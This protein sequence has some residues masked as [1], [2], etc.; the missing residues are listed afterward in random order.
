MNRTKLLI[1]PFNGN[2]LE[3]L[4]C[5]NDEE[6]EF[7]GFIDDDPEKTSEHYK[8]FQ[9]GILHQYPEFKLLAVPGGPES[10]QKRK[11]IIST[12]NKDEDRFIS[13]IHHTASIGRNVKIGSNCLIMA[14]VVLTSNAIIGNHVCILPNSVVHHDS[15]IGDYT[16]IGSKVV[17]AGSTSVG[18]N[19]YIG[20]GSNIK[21]GLSIGD[22]TLVGLGSNILG[23]VQENSKMVGN[24]ARDLNLQE[25]LKVH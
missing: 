16:L 9:R 17:V 2:G 15:I 14:G 24:P 3:A 19:C 1:F 20:S 12:I 18:T 21:N 4:D 13:V 5:L 23:N 10:F 25:R 11:A 6:I 8:I 7:V 22:K